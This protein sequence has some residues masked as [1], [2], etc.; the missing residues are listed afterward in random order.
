MQGPGEEC[1]ETD[2]EVRR[3]TGRYKEGQQDKHDKLQQ[4]VNRHGHGEG[5]HEQQ[6]ITKVNLKDHSSCN[7]SICIRATHLDTVLTVLIWSPHV[8]TGY[9]LGLTLGWWGDGH[10]DREWLFIT[11][12]GPANI[13]T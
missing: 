5:D 10:L 13:T 8:C 7:V 4:V 11:T 2:M 12:I 9:G 1:K 3:E 6:A